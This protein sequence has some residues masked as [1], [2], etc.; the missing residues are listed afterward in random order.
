M[1]SCERFAAAS[2]NASG[3]GWSGVSSVASRLA[4]TSKFQVASA[5][6]G[7]GIFAGDD[8]ALLGQAD[9]PFHGPGR[10]RQDRLIARAAAAPH[11]AASP[12]EEPQRDMRP[13]FEQLRELRRRPV[14][15]PIRGEEAAVLVAV[16]IAQHDVLLGPGGF[17]QSLDAGQTVEL[18][19]DGFGVAKIRDGLE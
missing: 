19:H 14:E 3:A 4:A 10:L 9:L 5:D 11:R 2:R 7:I 18:P 6:L 13:F 15:L 1:L 16:G 12:V 8:L 17:D